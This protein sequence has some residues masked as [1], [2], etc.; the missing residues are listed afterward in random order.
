MRQG[1]HQ[2]GAPPPFLLR[3]QTLR[4]AVGRR[5]GK[6][7]TSV[8][9]GIF[10]AQ[11]RRNGP[12]AEVRGRLWQFAVRCT[13]RVPH[14]P[15]RVPKP[16][17]TTAVPAAAPKPAAAPSAPPPRRLR[18]RANS[19]RLGLVALAIAAAHALGAHA[20][21]ASGLPAAASTSPPTLIWPPGAWTIAAGA[22]ASFCRSPMARRG[23]SRSFWR[24]SGSWPGSPFPGCAGC[25]SGCQR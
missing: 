19:M 2:P 20:V 9:S 23:C 22:A 6:S 8:R 14:K 3:L 13:A 24:G 12:R 4:S 18:P 5:A 21:H 25:R 17:P 11:E 15:G 1:V 10:G 16:A 7:W